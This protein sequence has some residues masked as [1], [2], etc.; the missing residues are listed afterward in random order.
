[1][2]INEHVK[3]LCNELNTKYKG[4]VPDR[5][6]LYAFLE[7]NDWFG[8][9]NIPDIYDFLHNG[10]DVDLPDDKQSLVM[11]RLTLWLKAYQ[12]DNSIKYGL[13]CEYAM[14][15]IPET[16]EA[17]RKYVHG[18]GVENSRD[19][20]CVLDFLLSELP[21]EICEMT[22]EQAET[23]TAKAGSQLPRTQGRIFSDFL[24]AVSRDCGKKR[25]QY[26]ISNRKNTKKEIVAYGL[27]E[28]SR[29]AY[30]IFNETSWTQNRLIEKACEN[31]TYANL[32]VYLAMHFIC[33]L[34]SSDIVRLPKPKLP[35]P[36][37]VM[38][39][40]VLSGILEDPGQ[41]SREIEYRLDVK[42]MKPNK[43]GHKNAT[44]EIHFFVPVS[45]E[46]AFGLML[47]I[48][49]SY[50]DEIAA[51]QPFLKADRRL[52]HIRSFWGQ[53]FADCLGDKDFLTL[54]ANKAYLQGLETVSDRKGNGP[55]GYMI[56][57]LARSHKGEIGKLSEVTDHYL[58]DAAFTGLDAKFVMRE[59]FERG[60]FGFIP[61]LLLESAFGQ[62]FT[63]LPVSDQT[64]LITQ[65]GLEPP[66]IEK[67]TEMR[68]AVLLQ[69]RDSIKQAMLIGT[70][71]ADIVRNLA[72]GR[73]GSKSSLTSCLMTAAGIGCQFP[74]RKQ[75]VGCRYEIH[76]KA[77]IHYL[78]K[79][80]QR[81]KAVSVGWKERALIRQI[82]LPV[83]TEY[84]DYLE[85]QPEVDM[86]L[87][88]AIMKAGVEGYDYGNSL[89]GE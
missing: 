85:N 52:T 57:A 19:I 51:G 86:E 50:H 38:R 42:P 81:M 13:L 65:I 18:L 37:Y 45:L 68:S 30:L 5:K 71:A 28:F 27:S 40:K 66:I 74:D 84:V 17:F 8:L 9:E 31:G 6:R 60:I 47:V 16:T 26:R 88:T 29:M 80:Y 54:R 46:K 61:H 44:P 35:E 70:S 3:A 67:L 43:T 59:M 89:L 23:L 11:E 72:V 73:A 32:W 15:F 14:A 25:I 69:A 2:T 77:Q 49:A 83:I 62:E 53:D 55:R 87:I 36:G 33:G 58:K 78:M 34:R 7:V 82:V 12:R 64:Q 76:T 4:T 79:E 20:W 39:Q 1:M 63:A 41:Y 22:D 56:A 75:C 10:Q 24:L 21:C 48:A